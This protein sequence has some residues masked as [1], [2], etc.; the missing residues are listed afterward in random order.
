MVQSAIVRLPPDLLWIG[1][2]DQNDHLT[3]CPFQATNLIKVERLAV[4]GLDKSGIALTRRFEQETGFS[5]HV[6]SREGD[7]AH[8]RVVDPRT[9]CCQ[10]LSRPVREI[11]GKA[12]TR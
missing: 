12:M 8:L 7:N 6:G 3:T 11:C 2:V 5:H 1:I 10:V 9:E 4:E